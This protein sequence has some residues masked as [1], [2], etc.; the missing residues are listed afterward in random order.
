[1]IKYNYSKLH[2]IQNYLFLYALS[3]KGIEN[4]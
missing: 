3:N 4:Q 2:R 1:M